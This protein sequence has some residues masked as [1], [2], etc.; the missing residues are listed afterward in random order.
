MVVLLQAPPSLCRL[1]CV[2][3]SEGRPAHSAFFFP[4]FQTNFFFLLEKLLHVVIMVQAKSPPHHHLLKIIKY[5]ITAPQKKNAPAEGPCETH[6]TF[7]ELS[8]FVPH[9]KRTWS[10]PSS[11][12]SSFRLFGVGG[13][14]FPTVTRQDFSTGNAEG[15]TSKQVHRDKLKD[16]SRKKRRKKKWKETRE[17]MMT[18]A[19]PWA[20]SSD[21][22]GRHLGAVSPYQRQVCLYAT[23]TCVLYDV[24]YQTLLFRRFNNEQSMTGEEEN[25]FK[26]ISD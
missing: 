19:L 24:T 12:A 11:Y 5:L 10:F 1:G 14:K 17:M 22:R 2:K 9:L 15:R 23:Y 16:I 4:P 18:V 7:F 25:I 20:E 3:Y 8:P 13:F 21:S 6:E 26:R